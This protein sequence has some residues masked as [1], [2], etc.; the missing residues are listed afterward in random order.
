ML[1]YLTPRLNSRGKKGFTLIELLVVIAIIGILSSIILASLDS[2]RKKGRDARR[3]ADIKQIQ[4][5]LDLY[6]D[7]NNAFPPDV[8]ATN[9]VY[10]FD[11]TVLTAPGYISAVPT[12]PST[13]K[14]YP[15]VAYSAGASANTT[16]ISYH[17][18]AEL[19]S[20]NH[21]GLQTDTDISSNNSANGNAKPPN[22]G[23][24]NVYSICSAGSPPANDFDGWSTDSSK[25]GSCG[26]TI[27]TAVTAGG[28][29]TEMCYDV[30]P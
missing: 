18:G 7:Q 23:A 10:T 27:G 19:E 16:C 8:G 20:A 22:Y 2:S 15:Y 11:P 6:Y 14:P 29:G 24:G 21:I 3:L 9:G 26:G 1:N 17:L 4:L 13:G 28:S 5:A 30:K 25:N 12:D